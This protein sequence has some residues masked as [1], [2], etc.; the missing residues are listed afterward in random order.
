MEISIRNGNALLELG[1][2]QKAVEVFEQLLRKTSPLELDRRTMIMKDLAMAYLRL[3]ERTNCFH[4]HTPESCIYP[5]SLAGSHKD[6]T[7]SQK[8][9]E[10][11]KQLLNKIQMI[12]NQNG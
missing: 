10:L 11:Y 7:G 3:G 4:N 9:I 5:I 12:L 2:E 6:K 8:A 1:Q